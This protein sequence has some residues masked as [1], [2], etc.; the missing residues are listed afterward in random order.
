MLF[1]NILYINNASRATRTSCYEIS[2]AGCNIVFHISNDALLPRDSQRRG[3]IMRGAGRGSDFN[4]GIGAEPDTR[5]ASGGKRRGEGE[6]KR[7][8]V[9]RFECS[10]RNE[11]AR[12]GT[13][14]ARAVSLLRAS[15][16]ARSQARSETAN[17]SSGQF[18]STAGRTKNTTHV[19]RA[20]LKNQFRKIILIGSAE[21]G[22]KGSEERSS[23]EKIFGWL[24]SRYR[25]TR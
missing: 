20:P 18:R 9:S 3:G 13:I 11:N 12:R 24:N 22:G 25:I 6:K 21:R 16:E 4:T 19:P 2:D 14:I 1:R 10:R 23:S 8:R 15:I 17:Q 5:R 7:E